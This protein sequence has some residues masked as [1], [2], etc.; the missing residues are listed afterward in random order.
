MRYDISLSTL[1]GQ[2]ASLADYQGSVLLIVNVASECGSTPQY[3]GLQALHE[4]Y[5]SKGFEV[6]GFPCNQF[7]KQEPGSAEQIREFCSNH[8]AVTFPMF[9]KIDVN[10]PNRHPLYAELA[11]TP[12]SGGKA[13]DVGWNFEKFLVARDGSVQRFRTKVEPDDPALVR[14]IEQAVAA[15]KPA[16]A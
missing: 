4:K 7:G 14:A 1:E 9:E 5:G 3:A 13:G 15:P 10:G 8:Y 11:G 12:D 6:L 16:R 2:P